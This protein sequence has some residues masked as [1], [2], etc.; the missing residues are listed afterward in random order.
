MSIEPD[1]RALFT[2]AEVAVIRST[3]EA[4]IAALKPRERPQWRPGM[5]WPV[6]SAKPSLR[7][8][9]VAVL[10]LSEASGQMHATAF[11]EFADHMMPLC[12]DYDHVTSTELEA[13]RSWRETW[14][15]ARPRPKPKP[16]P[17]AVEPAPA[18]EV[19]P[20]RIITSEL[21]D[22]EPLE[23]PAA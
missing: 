21:V 18:A 23:D 5:S 6:E 4:E 13:C 10:A 8:P 14:L 11:V 9:R 15:A 2:A 12:D 1:D 17:K 20:F 22:D 3:Y 7:D 19:F 16:K